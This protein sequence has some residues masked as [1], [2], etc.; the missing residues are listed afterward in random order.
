MISIW[1]VKYGL[2]ST[3]HTVEY[4]VSQ[5]K[6]NLLSIGCISEKD[7]K[8][9][10]KDNEQNVYF[11]KNNRLIVKINKFNN[12]LYKLNFTSIQW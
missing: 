5:L 1:S 7:I 6:K 2:K 10:F 12:K 11:Y 9:I 8:I 4:Y 3:H